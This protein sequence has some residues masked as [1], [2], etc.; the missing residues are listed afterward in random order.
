MIGFPAAVIW[1]ISEG[2][3][4]AGWPPVNTSLHAFQFVVSVL[5]GILAFLLTTASLT[6]DL[7]HP[8]NDLVF[9]R[10]APVAIFLGGKFL[11]VVTFVLAMVAT[12]LAVSLLFPVFYGVWTVYSPKPFLLVLLLGGIPLIVYACA[13]GLFLSALTGRSIIAFPLFLLYWFWAAFLRDHSSASVDMFDFTMRLYPDVLAIDVPI[14][15]IDYSFG[16]L[17][18]P[19]EPHLIM[20]AVLYVS[21]SVVLFACTVWIVGKRRG[22]RWSITWRR[23]SLG[24]SRGS[25]QPSDVTS[26]SE[27]QS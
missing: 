12:L 21:L 24:K 5:I 13:L 20:R 7:N 4:P 23:T 11:G 27:G 15:L 10:P 17:L 18:D 19:V 14:W 6:R 2:R 25:T 1:L 3:T 9:S 26:H 22:S 8:Q 16:R